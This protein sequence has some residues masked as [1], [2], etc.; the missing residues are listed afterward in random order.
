MLAR[1][2]VTEGLAGAGGFASTLTPAA[3]G[4]RPRLLTTMDLS[5][6]Q[7]E[8]LPPG[9][10]GSARETDPRGPEPK[11]GA[12]EAFTNWSQKSHTITF[13]STHQK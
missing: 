10:L 3:S 4:K 5:I 13:S 6:A 2:A 1:A 12:A 9:L 7:L 11:V 8:G